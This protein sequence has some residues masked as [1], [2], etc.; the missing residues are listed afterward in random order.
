MNVTQINDKKKLNSFIYSEPHCQFLQSWQWGEFQE[1]V[2]GE[3]FRLGV[4]AEG[5]LL[6]A[7]TIIKKNFLNKTYL[8]CPH[9]PILRA[10]AGGKAKELLFSEIA[11]LALKEKAIFFRFE[12]ATLDEQGGLKKTLDIQPKRTIVLNLEKTEKELLEKMGQK[13]RYNIRLA[14][15][16]G[17]KVEQADIS[18]YG[19]F[20]KLLSETGARDRFRLH[21]EKYY[22]EMLRVDKDF[23]KLFFAKANGKIIAGGIFSFCGD[24]ATYLHGAS[25]NADRNLMAPFL[26]QWEIVKRAKEYGCKYYDFYGIDEKKW[27]GVTRFKVGFGGEE[28]NY[29]GTFDLVYNKR[30][31]FAYRAI[32]RLYRLAQN[33][34]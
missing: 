26:L 23:I 10:R 24:T 34:Q 25:S 8:Y 15:K 33:I 4:E 19:T 1:H 17:V 2:G 28:I 32:R 18:E 27:P 21:S 13:T 7:A 20:W 31:Y 6:A 5:N 11:K 22:Q 30:W 3:V 29:P 14:E 9:G 12:P 16:K